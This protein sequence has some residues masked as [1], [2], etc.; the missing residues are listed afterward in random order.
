MKKNT[1]WEYARGEIA[2]FFVKVIKLLCF[3]NSTKNFSFSTVVE[4]LKIFEL[5]RKLSASSI[6]NWFKH[7]YIQVSGRGNLNAFLQKKF[8]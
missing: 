3:V 5:F 8:T 6:C 7:L 1:E 2:N 4:K